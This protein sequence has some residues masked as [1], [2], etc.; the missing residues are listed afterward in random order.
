V[1]LWWVRDYESYFDYP[2]SVSRVR[3]IFE[4]VA[5][6]GFAKSRIGDRPQLFIEYT[7]DER[8]ELAKIAADLKRISQAAQSRTRKAS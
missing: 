6:R 8:T 5:S 1:K 3:W 2:G 4:R 7:D